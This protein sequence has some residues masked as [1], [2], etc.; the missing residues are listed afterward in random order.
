MAVSLRKYPTGA[1]FWVQKWDK[2]N[3]C[4]V[5]EAATIEDTGTAVLMQDSEGYYDIY[6]P[7]EILEPA[8][9]IAYFF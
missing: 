6:L 7:D 5:S 1:W 4:K 2:I 8:H 9:P 3:L